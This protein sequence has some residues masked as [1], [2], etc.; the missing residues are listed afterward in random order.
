MKDLLDYKDQLLVQPKEVLK[1][2]FGIEFGDDVEIKV[3]FETE[4]V[5][6]IV[7]PVKSTELNEQEI[8]TMGKGPC[9]TTNPSTH[10]TRC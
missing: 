2:E 3:L 9:S 7:I 4:K 6:Y 10:T 5:K 1:E 8:I